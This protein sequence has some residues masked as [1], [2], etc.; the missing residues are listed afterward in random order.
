MAGSSTNNNQGKL[1]IMWD[2]GT[3][4]N[5]NDNHL[6]QVT[7]YETIDYSKFDPPATIW[8]VGKNQL[9]GLTKRRLFFLATDQEGT[10]CSARLP[11]V[12]VVGHKCCLYIGRT[13]AGKR[14]ATVIC[15]RLNLDLYRIR[16]P[17]L[18]HTTLWSINKIVSGIEQKYANVKT[19]F[20]VKIIARDSLQG[21]GGTESESHFR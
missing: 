21:W 15:N 3:F 20:R 8:L 7:E 10:K 5:C 18:K 19:G 12:T 6:L 9:N 14:V 11:P 1:S 16:V 17:L 2:C 4:L 13:A